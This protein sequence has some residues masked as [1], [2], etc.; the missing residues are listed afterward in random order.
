MRFKWL[1]YISDNTIIIDNWLDEDTI[2]Y[3]RCDSGWDDYINYWMADD[4]TRWNENFFCKMVFDEDIPCSVIT[5]CMDK[6]SKITILEFIVA[7]ILRDKGIGTAVLS[8]LLYHS[9]SILGKE[10]QK[11]EAVIYPSNV[12]SQKVFTNAGF[13]FCHAHPDGDAWYYRYNSSKSGMDI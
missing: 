10:I 13:V 4:Q 9:Y 1:D 2:K 7:P 8:E 12:A 6:C 5:V 11:A 3:T